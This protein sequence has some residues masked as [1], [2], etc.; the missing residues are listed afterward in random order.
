[1]HNFIINKKMLN[2]QM[3]EKNAR[4]MQSILHCNFINKLIKNNH[5]IDEKTILLKHN[6]D[7]LDLR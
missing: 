1:M 4:E 6:H 5:K 2:A 7:T 3:I